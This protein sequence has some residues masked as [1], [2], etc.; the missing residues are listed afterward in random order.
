MKLIH[1]IAYSALLLTAQSMSAAN[2]MAN[3]KILRVDE[4]G[5]VLKLS[6]PFF[7][8]WTPGEKTP[9]ARIRFEDLGQKISVCLTE[10]SSIYP[11][12]AE[13]T[14]VH[15][16]ISLP[17]S[18]PE[19]LMDRNCNDYQLKKNLTGTFFIAAVYCNKNEV[20]IF[21]SAPT[22]FNVAAVKNG[23]D[24]EKV[25]AVIDSNGKSL[26]QIYLKM[27]PRPVV[28]KPLPLIV[29]PP[30]LPPPPPPL[31]IVKP[32]RSPRPAARIA[33]APPPLRYYS[34]YLVHMMLGG[35]IVSH[36]NTFQTT[37]HPTALIQG[38]QLEV[39]LNA[40]S[41]SPNRFKLLF[42][43]EFRMMALGGLN[44]TYIGNGYA[45]RIMTTMQN[46]NSILFGLGM[47]YVTTTGT[48]LYG[49]KDF[50]G[51]AIKLML[52]P[53]SRRWTV[54]AGCSPFFQGFPN[55]ADTWWN[56]SGKLTI[57]A[58][59]RHFSI[60]IDLNWI[61]ATSQISDSN[62]VNYSEHSYGF[63]MGYR[64]GE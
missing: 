10:G 56:I 44:T 39:Y 19:V 35:G 18:H 14:Q 64:F 29:L 57:P 50:E 20:Q 51:P 28:K 52:L 23:N 49:I 33:P 7:W 8:Q 32:T 11:P 38:H 25:F 9:C 47:S 63:L 45:E 36:E 42:E 22:L 55:L 60:G 12:Q 1:F 15:Y 31:P 16:N 37:A 27:K 26:G 46:K 41:L 61:G 24:R 17:Y 21:T 62:Q 58:I 54:S 3:S 40:L 53:E 30:P 6:A 2:G 48:G 34:K 5:E 43:G 13:P 4:S 59:S